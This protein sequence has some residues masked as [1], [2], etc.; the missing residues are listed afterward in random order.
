MASLTRS[1]DA[2]VPLSPWLG[3]DCLHGSLF[4]LSNLPRNTG[5]KLSEVTG[6]LLDLF[7]IFLA[8]KVAAE[9]FERIHQPPVIGE[10]LAGLLIGPH[11]LGLIGTPDQTLVQAFHGDVPSAQE[12]VAITYRLLAELGVVVLLFFVGLET[13]IKDIL[14]V[15][16]RAT[17]VAVMGVL[18]PFALGFVLMGPILGHPQIES[19]FVGVAMVATSVG[20]TARVLRDLH[21]ISSMESRIIL[22]AAV[23]DDILAMIIL[24]T[25][26]GLARSGAVSLLEIGFIAGQAIL[27]T[28][29]VALVGTGV[30]SRFALGLNHLRMDN[31]P[32]AVALLAM[33]GLASLAAHIG[34]AAIIGAFLAGMV[35]AEAREHFELEHQ[36]L[37]IFQFLV[38]FFF[39][40]TGSEVD[41]RMFLD[42]GIIGIALTVTALALLGK[43]IGCGLAMVGLGRRSMAI[44]GVGMSP[45]GEVGLIVAS[46]GLSLGAIPAEIFSVVVIM[47]ILTT[48]IAP[49]ILRVLFAG[50]STAETV[51]AEAESEAG[52]LPDL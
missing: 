21:V 26:S 43:L 5:G 23:I 1:R 46:L 2:M 10:L 4:F 47:S 25:M 8:A 3:G 37:P 19:M 29:F 12:A 17:T 49:P 13:Q 38:P 20:I 24:A 44:V 30:V 28:V 15:G 22:G 35:F 9:V 7:V 51:P 34:L 33:L 14:R 48:F 52:R 39:V 31:A 18:L 41:W 6:L 36:A 42:G 11:A 32:F 27:F 16:G 45:R 50:K 40:L